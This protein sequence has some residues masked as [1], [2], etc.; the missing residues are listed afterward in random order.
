MIPR[1]VDIFQ[2]LRMFYESD[3]DHFRLKLALRHL[4]IIEHVQRLN[5]GHPATPD[6]PEPGSGRRG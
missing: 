5:T 6:I 4:E 3:G 1:E 2:A